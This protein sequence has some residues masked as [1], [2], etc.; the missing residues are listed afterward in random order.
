MI[1]KILNIIT[2]WEESEQSEAIKQVRFIPN[3]VGRP[4]RCCN[5]KK[6]LQFL[7]SFKLAQN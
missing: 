1:G 6:I 4:G 7:P 2:Y 5:P 3:T